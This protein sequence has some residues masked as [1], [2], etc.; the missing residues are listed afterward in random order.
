MEYSYQVNQ[1]EERGV[2][3]KT[4]LYVP[5]VHPVTQE[6]F[7]EREDEGHVFKRIGQ[8]TRMGGPSEFQ[9]QLLC[10][11]ARDAT[12]NLTYAALTGQRKQSIG[13]VERLFNPKVAEFMEKNGHFFEAR[14]LRVIHNWRRAVDERGLTQVQRSEFCKDFLLLVLDEL[15]P[16]HGEKYDFSTLEVNRPVSKVC[17]FSRETLIAVT[18][19][20]ESRELKRITNMEEGLSPEHPR[21]STTDDVECFFSILRDSVGKHFTVKQ[22]QY[23][24]RKLSIEF[25]KRM[26]PDLQY[27]YFTASHDRFHEGP[28]PGFDQP[29]PREKRSHNPRHQ[30][31]PRRDQVGSLIT[32]R[33]TMVTPGQLSTR[34]QFHHTPIQLPPPPGVDSSV[35]D[36]S[37]A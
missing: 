24:Y 21:A 3:F 7:H 1:W 27:Y 13:D 36:H 11:A 29:R 14:Y 9:L 20:I 2:P 19:D 34:V 33:A 5:E 30:R 4:N 16:W 6:Y 22:V 37:Y 10:K 18:T 17:G 31:V 32:G 12:T 15:M 23:T 35:V 26:D 25:I 28:L 8:H